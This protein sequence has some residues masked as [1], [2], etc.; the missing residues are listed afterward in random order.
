MVVTMFYYHF[1]SLLIVS[2]ESRLWVISYLFLFRW[3]AFHSLNP[4]DLEPQR[5]ARLALSEQ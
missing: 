1:V 3:L 5:R 2:L 4:H